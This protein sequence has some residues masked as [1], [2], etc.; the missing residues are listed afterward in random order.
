[1]RAMAPVKRPPGAPGRAL[2]R[3][4]R[5]Y[6]IEGSAGYLLNR[7]ANIIAAR[8]SDVLKEHEINLQTWRVLAALST[9]PSRSLTELASHTAAEL[10]YLSRAAAGAEEKGLLTRSA[11]PVDARTV[12]LS[13]T[14]RGRGLVAAIAPE[15]LLIESAAL[16]GVS[17]TDTRVTLRTLHAIYQ[18]LVASATDL[19]VKNR[20]LAVAQ[21]VQRRARDTG[22]S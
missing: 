1:M 16:A 6:D 13:L 15:A 20:K 4:Q 10:S 7:A 11:S 18:N 2:A 12:L 14:E 19:P 3:R 21:R 17:A 5:T 8:F 22:P 9:A